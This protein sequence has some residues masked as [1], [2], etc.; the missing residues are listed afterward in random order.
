MLFT[1]LLLQF[2]QQFLLKVG[3]KNKT[4]LLIDGWLETLMKSHLI[5]LSLNQ[6][7]DSMLKLKMFGLIQTA[8][9]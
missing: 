9:R 1:V 7:L 5:G 6:V 4:G 8:Q 3:N 2:G